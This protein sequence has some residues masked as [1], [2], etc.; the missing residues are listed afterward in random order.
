MKKLLIVC[1][2]DSMIWNFL[3]PHIKYLEDN[4]YA[5]E[6]VCSKTGFYFDELRE[7]YQINLERIDFVRTPYSF[8]NIIAI[9]QLIQLVKTRDYDF[10]FCHEPVGGVAGRIVG[11]ICKIKVIYMAHGFHFYKGASLFNR[12]VYYSVE[13]FLSYFTYALVTINEE[14]YQVTKIFH[15]RHI[16]KVDG[17]GID[18]NRIKKVSTNFLRQTYSLPHNSM[19][20]LSVGELITRK[21]HQVVIEMM[22]KFRNENVYYFIAGEGSLLENL[23]QR[24]LN[25]GLENQIFFLGFCKNVQD[26]YNSCDIFIFPSIHEGLPMALMEAMLCAKP[27]VSSNIRGNVDLVDEGLG[28][29]LID[30]YDVDG[31]YKSVQ[32]LLGDMSL[33]ERMGH[34]NEKKVKKM[35]YDSIKIEILKL[36]QL[37]E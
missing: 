22:K 35:G 13:K 34:Y 18:T 5:V 30:S 26:L 20:L 31:Y 9:K 21:N 28:G 24:V 23:K 4:G 1:T 8:K 36:F 7:K 17:I 16:R 11:V 2:T 14:D 37:E 32:R 33:R 29:M 25:L 3:I 10:I 15:S 19:V 27:V 12:I 6:C